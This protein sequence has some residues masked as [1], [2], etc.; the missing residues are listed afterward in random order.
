MLDILEKLREG[1]LQLVHQT[2]CPDWLISGSGAVIKDNSLKHVIMARDHMKHKARGNTGDPKQES[3]EL[4]HES[5]SCD[6][7]HTL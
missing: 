5:C 1:N 4:R 6:A 7:I 3:S 2:E